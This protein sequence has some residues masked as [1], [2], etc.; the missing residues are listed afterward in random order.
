MQRHAGLEPEL[1]HGSDDLD[2]GI[3]VARLRIAPGRPHAITRRA[4]VFCL[5]CLGN[6]L[7]DLHQLGGCKSCRMMRRLAA[8]AAV[9]R[10]TTCLDVQQPAQLHA[11]WVKM[12]PMYGL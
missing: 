12:L 5:A 11:I 9:F 10:T 2:N 7:P 8:V 6:D 4:A 3:H 1:L